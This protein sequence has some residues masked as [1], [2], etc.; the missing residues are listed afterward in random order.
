MNR[1]QVLTGACNLGDHCYAVGSVEG[2][3]FTAYA[4]GCN[5]VIL[6]SN[7][8]R[9]QII[10]GVTHGNI[11]VSCIDCSSDTGKIAASYGRKVH[12]FE[13]TPLIHETSHKLDYC[14]YRTATIEVDCVI[15]AITWNMEGSKLLTGGENISIWQFEMADN[16]DDDVEPNNRKVQFSL[17]TEDD[18]PIVQQLSHVVHGNTKDLFYHGPGSWQCVWKCK[19]AT[20]VY[21]VKF[22]PDGF[23]F[24][25]AG[26]ADRL[27]KIWY[28]DRKVTPQLIR[29]DSISPKKEELHYSFVYIA[30]PRAVTGFSWRKTSKYMPRGS[31]ANMLVTSC[32]DNVCRVWCET[33]LPDD[34][35]LDLEQ[36]DPSTSLDSKF[37]TSR[38]KKR[39]IQRLKTI[40]HAIHKRRKQPK[41]NRETVMSVGNLSSMGSVHDFHKF[42]IHHNGV[43]PVLHFHL[44]GSINPET[45]IPLQLLINSDGL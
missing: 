23:L 29:S 24:A 19:P 33:I 16:T 9:V 5:I 15:N 6:A 8:E 1:H 4:A 25:T 3:H 32:L 30:H 13:P 7:F 31:V 2:I 10:P 42:A 14:W 28:E 44:A 37:T 11:K 17:G 45:D 27:V 34:G 20:T 26:K 22:S 43:S 39:F 21:H 38:H 35:L 36:F 41:Y 40:R 12:I 18:D